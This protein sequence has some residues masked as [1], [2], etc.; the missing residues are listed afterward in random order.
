MLYTFSNHAMQQMEIRGISREMVDKVIL[1]PD[2]RLEQDGLIIY[3]GFIKEENDQNYLI[4]VFI[5][6]DK[7]PALVVTVYKTS[8]IGKYY[9]SK[10]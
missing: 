7:D 5:N 3:Q 6:F 8:K 10:I 1:K 9:E 4:R 2:Q